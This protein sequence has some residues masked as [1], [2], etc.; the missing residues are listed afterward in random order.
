MVTGICVPIFKIVVIYK[1]W[2][3]I[4]LYGSA[5]YILPQ[6]LEFIQIDNR[7]GEGGGGAGLTFWRM[8]RCILFINNKFFVPLVCDKIGLFSTLK[9]FEPPILKNLYSLVWWSMGI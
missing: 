4:L 3:N 2:T 7:S 9:D 1:Y 6:I 8:Y 5:T